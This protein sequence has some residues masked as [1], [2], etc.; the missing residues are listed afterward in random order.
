MTARR[1]LAER[2]W[3]KV[4][5]G[6]ADQCWPWLAPTNGAGY[7]TVFRGGKRQSNMAL[8]HRV[9]FELASGQSAEGQC[10]C[11]RCD[12]PI[13]CNP[14]H[15]FLGSHAENSRDMV[16]KGRA[17][18][19]HIYGAKQHSAKLTDDLV[20][21]LRANPPAGTMAEIGARYGLSARGINMVLRGE[22]WRHVR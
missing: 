21:Q 12:N 10:V 8:A 7:G 4:Q 9:A 13:C 11:H 1:T 5:I 14:G 3:P 2:F 16:R 19:G 20:R 17:R 18:P 15:L 22:T 6:S